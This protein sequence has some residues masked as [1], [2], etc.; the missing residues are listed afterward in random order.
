MN[1]TQVRWIANYV[2]YIIYVWT[3]KRT[4]ENVE[5]S[6]FRIIAKP[7]DDSFTDSK[8]KHESSVIT[9]CF[10]SLQGVSVQW[11]VFLCITGCFSALHGV[12]L[13]YRVFLCIAGCFCSI[14]GVSMHYR[15]FLFITG[16]FSALQG[17]SLY[18]RVSFFNK[19]CF[20]ALQ[21]VSIQYIV[22]LFIT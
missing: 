15:V 4:G 21:G 22:C 2:N 18:C 20:Y 11:R 16:C 8:W 6:I 10:Y 3:M 5:K 17:V 1:R 7:E 9:G 12:S 19:G 14:K 13:H